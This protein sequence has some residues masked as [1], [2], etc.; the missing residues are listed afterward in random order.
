MGQVLVA[1][2]RLLCGGFFCPPP[3]PQMST[4]ALPWQAWHRPSLFL[5]PYKKCCLSVSCCSPLVMMCPSHRAGLNPLGSVPGSQALVSQ[6]AKA[7][8][9]AIL[10]R[11]G[12]DSDETSLRQSKTVLSY[13][14]KP[15]CGRVGWVSGVWMSY[16]APTVP[17][18][19]HPVSLSPCPSVTHQMSSVLPK[20]FLPLGRSRTHPDPLGPSHGLGQSAGLRAPQNLRDPRLWPMLEDLLLLTKHP[21]RPR[22]DRGGP[23]RM[24]RR[25]QRRC[26]GGTKEGVA[27]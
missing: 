17:Y 2:W 3:P 10:D 22:G 13:P 27:A 19:C 7:R 18:S 24:A 26:R 23:M 16:N 6:R 12:H 1:R 4:A 14:V 11:L 15:V 20:L 5:S 25:N 9:C 8:S 21:F